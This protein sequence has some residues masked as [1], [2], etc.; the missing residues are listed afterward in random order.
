MAVVHLQDGKC[1]E[2]PAEGD[3]PRWQTSQ[4]AKVW[5]LSVHR[6]VNPWDA[7]QKEAYLVAHPPP[8]HSCGDFGGTGHRAT[9]VF[10]PPRLPGSS[11]LHA[12]IGD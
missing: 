1:L 4:T 3:I 2:R 12:I 6:M 7:L 9:V 11:L 8:V 5:M 10:A